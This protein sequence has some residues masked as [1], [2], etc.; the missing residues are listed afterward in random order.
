MA[1]STLLNLDQNSLRYASGDLYGLEDTA[2]R[3]IIPAKFSDIEYC[4][5]GLFLATE[6]EPSSNYYFG[7][8]RSIFNREGVE[9]AYKLPAGAVLLNIFSFGKEADRDKGF[10]LDKLPDDMTFLFAYKD[11]PD[12]SL[13]LAKQGICTVDGKLLLPATQ[14]RILF[15]EPGQAF[16]ER[17]KNSCSTADFET[18][19]IKPTNLRYSNSIP[20]RRTPE[21]GYPIPLPPDRF[22]TTKISTSQKFDSSY[23][24]E[25]RYSPVSGFEMFNR[26][27]KENDL[28]GMNRTQVVDLLGEPAVGPEWATKGDAHLYR[29]GGWSCI[30]AFSGVKVYFQKNRVVGWSFIDNEMM[31][32]EG[33]ESELIK[34]NVLLKQRPDNQRF[35]IQTE[36]TNPFPE[37]EAKYLKK[38]VAEKKLDLTEQL[39]RLRT[40]REHLLQLRKSADVIWDEEIAS[41]F[42]LRQTNDGFWRKH[43]QDKAIDERIEEVEY[44]IES[45]E[46]TNWASKNLP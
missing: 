21:H 16:I 41:N 27:L 19:T 34:S 4:G 33:K 22:K 2:G 24:K 9:L 32:H 14:A 42:S 40:L 43:Y 1:W 17:P 18:W 13:D 44:R 5:H 8:K 28:I 46:K 25:R 12:A 26:F 3:V 10:V 7:T 31:G 11:V 29:F 36:Q 23:F 15:L 38:P 30:G 45:L 37:V 20:P 6:T 39:K 35:K